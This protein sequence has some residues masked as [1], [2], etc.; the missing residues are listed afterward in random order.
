MEGHCGIVRNIFTTK[1]RFTI[2]GASKIDPHSKLNENTVFLGVFLFSVA[3][4]Q[5]SWHVIKYVAA[6]R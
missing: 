2:T 3:F 1:L 6:S 4:V 5:C